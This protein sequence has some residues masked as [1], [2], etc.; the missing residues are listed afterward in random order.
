MVFRDGIPAWENAGFPITSLLPSKNITIPEVN[1]AQL[2]NSLD[3]YLIVD[4]RPE[5]T[6]SDGYLTGSRAMPLTYLK[7]LSVELPSDRKIM[8]VDYGGKRCNMA[9]K[10][11]VSRGYSNISVLKGGLTE[12]A[13]AGFELEK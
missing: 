7:M 4:I 2:H 13:N 12:Y 5:S 6:Y 9:A 11:L 1:A 10:W 3:D 8:I